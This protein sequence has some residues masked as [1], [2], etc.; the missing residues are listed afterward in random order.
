MLLGAQPWRAAVAWPERFAGGIAHRLDVPT[1][2]AVW[3]ADDLEELA[4]MRRWFAEGALRKIYRFEAARD[5]PWDA[6]VVDL[7]IGH[8]RRR[9]S[10]M[11]V[12]RGAHTPHRGRWYA[13][14]TEL[15]RI[16]DGRWEAAITTGVTHQIRLHAAF[17]GLPLR[18][19]KLYGGGPPLSD[20][21]P[22]HLHHVG[23]TGPG[24]AGTDPVEDP[25]WMC[26]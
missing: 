22:F 18:G 15:R 2:G 10:R 25:P 16:G 11:V 21:V 13:A 17:V 24:D 12:R 5:V 3:V 23:L 20:E 8:D 14:H 4:R 7:D 6:H 26:A 19:D 9:R 1:S